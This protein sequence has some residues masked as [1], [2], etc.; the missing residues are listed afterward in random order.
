MGWFALQ[1]RYCWTALRY[2]EKCLIVGSTQWPIRP[3]SS[4][5]E[6]LFPCCGPNGITQPEPPCT[7]GALTS[8]WGSVCIPS[9]WDLVLASGGSSTMA[10]LVSVSL[11]A[12]RP[13]TAS[14]VSAP[15]RVGK[16]G[17]CRDA[18]ERSVGHVRSG[19]F[20]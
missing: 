2:S 20:S 5:T 7:P 15:P 10:W 18:K 8:P 14:W 11:Q 4:F 13:R 3:L 19:F 12:S 6:Q 17:W 9:S 16:L 1:V